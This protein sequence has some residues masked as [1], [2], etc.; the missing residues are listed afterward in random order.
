MQFSP[1][2]CHFIY[3]YFAKFLERVM[4]ISEVNSFSLSNFHNGSYYIGRCYENVVMY[5]DLRRVRASYIIA[6][7]RN[8]EPNIHTP[9]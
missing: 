2:S 6:Q 8:R 1:P 3:A 9:S 4:K 7:D 5:R